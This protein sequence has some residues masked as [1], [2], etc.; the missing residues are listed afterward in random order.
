MLN[1]VNRKLLDESIDLCV[2]I[3]SA[4]FTRHD[5]EFVKGLYNEENDTFNAKLLM[6]K[7]FTSKTP[8]YIKHLT[9]KWVSA[10]PLACYADFLECDSMNLISK[11]EQMLENNKNIIA[12]L[13]EDDFF[14]SKSDVIETIKNFKQRTFIS[15][16]EYGH[17][18][19]IERPMKAGKLVFKAIK[20]A[21]L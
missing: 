6:E 15:L 14:Y 4:R 19:L 3:S 2:L 10:L 13:G 21:N 9:L 18:F 17:L 20:E 5:N 12:F 16:D 7:N 1:I 8:W 11:N